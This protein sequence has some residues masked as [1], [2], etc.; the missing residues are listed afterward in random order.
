MAVYTKIPDEA[1]EGFI[2]EYD[3]G[4]IQFLK[5]I[6]EGVEN[7][8]FLLKTD[9]G[10][11]ILTIYEK[12]VDINDLPFFLGLMDHL[13]SKKFPCPTPLHGFDG[14]ALRK[15]CDKPA[16]LISFMS[17]LGARNITSS[18]C[19]A[20][21]R[22]AAELHMAGKDFN[23]SR[24]NSLDIPAWRKIFELTKARAGEIDD[25]IVIEI[26]NELKIL[27]Q[28]WPKNLPSGIIHADLFPDNVFFKGN[29]LSGIID[30]Y[31]ACNG[32]LAYEIAT[33]IN[34]W[35]FEKDGSFNAN[36]ASSLLEGYK[37]IRPLEKTEIDFLPLLARGSALRFLLTRL[38]DLLNQPEG[39]L[40]SPKDPLEYLERLRFH[41]IY[42]GNYA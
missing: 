28:N 41:K 8:N 42:S 15:L 37:S 24:E 40:V 14:K 27:D 38:Y 26:E 39:A 16:A 4:K 29:K 25:G 13:A 3:I 6:E 31:F 32:F 11:Y 1:L 19:Y 7:S 10:T 9:R 23:L 35:C 12:R 33:C 2:E 5:G 17:G 34:A 21:G 36:K 30:F 20:V 22:A 18:H